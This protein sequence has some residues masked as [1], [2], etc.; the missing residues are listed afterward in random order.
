MSQTKPVTWFADDPR[1]NTFFFRSPFRDWSFI[2]N[3]VQMA[4]LLLF[5]VVVGVRYWN[6]ISDGSLFTAFISFVLFVVYP[7]GR[8][9]RRHRKIQELYLSGQI[10]APSPESPLNQIL[11]VADRSINEDVFHST[12][13]FALLFVTFVLYKIQ[14]LK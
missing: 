2:A 7:Y 10:S 12:L 3:T 6:Q 8:A 4:V 5:M 14:H 13:L 9:L 11:E 1:A